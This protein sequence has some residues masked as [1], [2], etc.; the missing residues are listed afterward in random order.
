MDD[1]RPQP[2][3][4]PAWDE[5][6]AGGPSKPLIDERHIATAISHLVV[7]EGALDNGSARDRVRQWGSCLI[8][9]FRG[10][11]FSSKTTGTSGLLTLGWRDLPMNRE[12]G[13][14][15]YGLWRRSCAWRPRCG[16]VP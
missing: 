13:R 12:F 8:F 15:P 6:F 16:D 1:S 7:T 5:A 10:P 4:P 14:V 3:A 9:V 11:H 2:T